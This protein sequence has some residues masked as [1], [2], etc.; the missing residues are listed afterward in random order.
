MKYLA[1][2]ECVVI[3]GLIVML[4]CGVIT[5]GETEHEFEE[6]NYRVES[7]DTL[8]G[9]AEDYCPNTMD[10]RSYISMVKE[11]NGIE[12]SAIYPGQRL[13]VFEVIE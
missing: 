3:V 8:W 13:V 5:S 7:G 10:I 9:I 11:R 12:E 6:V 4:A 2:I 1:I